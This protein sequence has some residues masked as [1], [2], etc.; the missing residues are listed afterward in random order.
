MRLFRR[1]RPSVQDLND[2]SYTTSPPVY[3]HPSQNRLQPRARQVPPPPNVGPASGTSAS[4]HQG[5]AYG[6]IDEQA[7][8][9]D[10]WV[11]NRRRQN[12]APL[13]Q[14]G[15]QNDAEPFEDDEKL[16]KEINLQDVLFRQLEL[17]QAEHRLRM[18][19]EE[20]RRRREQERREAAE[21]DARFA[22]EQR[23]REEQE[24]REAA[25]AH[26]RLAEERRRRQEER[27]GLAHEIAARQQQAV[28]NSTLGRVR[29]LREMIREKRRLDI[30][31]WDDRGVQ[32]DDQ[33]E[34]KQKCVKADGLMD[35]IVA[36]IQGWE[37][38]QFGREEWLIVSKI[39]EGMTAAL[40]DYISWTK[41]PPWERQQMDDLDTHG[42]T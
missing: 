42:W 15:R 20:K 17:D 8:L 31:I 18:E 26:A 40:E 33:E 39:N 6:V 11:Q 19:G 38:D 2:N 7:R 9:L 22:D 37:E 32:L 35:H 23:R 1:P 30:E 5:Q 25:E 36:I 21:A 4:D 34:V 16:R 24:Q 28:Q 12:A 13:E 3:E 10:M 41:L 29:E 14:N 27:E